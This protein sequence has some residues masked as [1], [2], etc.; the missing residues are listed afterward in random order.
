[1]RYLIAYDVTDNQRRNRLARFLLDY[2][3]RVQY[4]AFECE[5][6]GPR[7]DEV[8]QGVV[9]YMARQ[10]DNV[11]VYRLCADCAGKIQTFGP[12]RVAGPTGTVIV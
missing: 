8:L 11:R 6:T 12:Q 5:L 3:D 9:K 7:L 4:S 2:G 10:E 1:M